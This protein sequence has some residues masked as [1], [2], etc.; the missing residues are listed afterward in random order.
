MRHTRTKH[1]SVSERLKGWAYNPRLHWKVKAGST[2][3]TRT[4]NKKHR[5]VDLKEDTM[6][7]DGKRKKEKDGKTVDV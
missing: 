6:K 2:P 4:K 5:S 1:A 3:A 7:R